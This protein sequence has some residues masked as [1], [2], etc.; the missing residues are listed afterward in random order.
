MILEL[1]AWCKIGVFPLLMH[2]SYSSFALNFE[3][4]KKIVG[5]WK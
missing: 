1:M 3:K 5:V 4:L 2:S